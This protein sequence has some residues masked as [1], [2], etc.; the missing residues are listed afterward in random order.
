MVS[1]RTAALALAVAA[2]TGSVGCGADAWLTP[3]QQ[4]RRLFA[5]G[6]HAEAAERFEDPAW[7]ATA[8]YRAGDHAC[9]A[10]AFAR[11]DTAAAW[12]GLGNSRALLDDLEGA[13][14]AYDRA[15][16]K[17]PGW[18]EAEENRALVAAVAEARRRMDVPEEEEQASGNPNLDPD[19]IVFDE[20]GEKGTEGEIPTVQATDAA[21]EA[22]WLRGVRSEPAEFL[23]LKFAVE[24]ARQEDGP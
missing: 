21:I 9:A 20:K 5:Q 4:G 23:R 10:D 19:E 13:I 17:A 1:A 11:L 8:C 3:D 18:T 15:L 6:R 14:E 7:R 22:M 2:A 24:A 12:F 16:A